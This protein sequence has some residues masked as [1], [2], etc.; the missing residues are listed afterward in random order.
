M[1]FNEITDSLAKS[2][3]ILT[4]TAIPIFVADAN[5]YDNS[6]FITPSKIE[7]NHEITKLNTDRKTATTIT[8]LKNETPQALEGD[9]GTKIYQKYEICSD[10]VL[11]PQ[12]LKLAVVRWSGTTKK[13]N[14]PA[15]YKFQWSAGPVTFNF[16]LFF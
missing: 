2:A 16:S 4:Q 6:K 3:I 15:K 12:G 5:A 8:R 11:T 9:D 10:V 7:L 1:E 14:G 13:S